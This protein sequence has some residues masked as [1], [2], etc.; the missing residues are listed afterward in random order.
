MLAAG[1]RRVGGAGGCPTV[2]ARI[3]SAAGVQTDGTAL[4]A[5]DDHLVAG[6]DCCV[7]FSASGRVSG[8]GGCPTV[9]ARV[10]ST[11][12]IQIAGTALSAP[13]DHFAGAV[14]PYGRVIVSR[15]GRVGEAGGCPTVGA[16]IVSAAGVNKGGL[17]VAVKSAPDDHFSSGPH[18]R[19]IGSGIRS[20]GEAGG[21]PTVG[22]GIVSPTSIRIAGDVI[23]SA[24]EGRSVQFRPRQSSRCRS[25]P[26]CALAGG[27]ARWR[28][29]S[30]YRCWGCISRR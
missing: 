5:P 21:C 16:G 14:V 30:N 26:P 8:A 3:V 22:A 19:V 20:V 2:S 24:P 23:V 13:D 29:L 9:S 6:P 25:R 18:C 17:D 7:I 27:P 4:S 10:V 15:L 28:L 12:G 11:A 1:S